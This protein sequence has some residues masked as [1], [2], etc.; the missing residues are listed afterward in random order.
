MRGNDCI[1]LLWL[2]QCESMA[3]F[4]VVPDVSMRFSFRSLEQFVQRYRS[5]QSA[6]RLFHREELLYIAGQGA[7]WIPRGQHH[8]LLAENL[9]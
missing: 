8:W 5:L 7:H 2:V 1:L 9:D 3:C 6:A 4:R